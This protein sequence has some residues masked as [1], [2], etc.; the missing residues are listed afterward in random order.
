MKKTTYEF[1]IATPYGDGLVVPNTGNSSTKVQLLD[2]NPLNQSAAAAEYGYDSVS[3]RYT[4]NAILYTTQPYPSISPKVKQTV[5]TPYG[6]GRV[7]A[8]ANTNTKNQIELTSWRLA[9][10]CSVKLYQS[11]TTDIKVIRPLPLQQCITP[12]DRIEFALIQK[13][14]A[15]QYYVKDR[16]YKSALYYYEYAIQSVRSVQ[17]TATQNNENECRADLVELIITCSNNAASCCI[18]LQQ[19]KQCLTFATNALLILNTL[20]DKRGKKIHSILL[21][22]RSLDK[23]FL[24]NN[25]NLCDEKLF[26]EWRIKCH[27]LQAHVYLNHYKDYNK[28]LMSLKTARD[29]CDLYT[30]T[31][32]ESKC[33]IESQARLMKIKKGEVTKLMKQAVAL[34]NKTKQNEKARAQAMFGGKSKKTT[35]NAE[36]TTNSKVATTTATTNKP[37]VA[38]TTTLETV[39]ATT[40]STVESAELSTEPKRRVSFSPMVQERVIEPTTTTEEDTDEPWYEEHKEALLLVAATGF[41]ALS[42]VLFRGTSKS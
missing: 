18:Q 42:M 38:T 36:T 11:T 35:P 7:V 32:S 28:A 15:N 4:S 14:H 40:T 34:K 31:P 3:T 9:N 21:R 30:T 39:T 19:Y 37:T 13:Q 5:I 22:N 17:H 16:N 29:L 6:I 23:H 1:I 2:W 24:C 10:R 25:S 27:L 26:G 41:A 8:A 33:S 20:F 12:W